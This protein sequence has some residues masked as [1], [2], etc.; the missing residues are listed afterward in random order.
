MKRGMT[1]EIERLNAWVDL[2]EA[3][4]IRLADAND[5]L[6]EIG[7]KQHER[8]AELEAAL[9]DARCDYPH[10]GDYCPCG[11]SKAALQEVTDECRHGST[12]VITA[13]GATGTSGGD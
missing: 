3:D 11:W 12:G 5:A 13:E 6:I 1:L 10:T 4:R 7:H 2:I 9:R 8:I